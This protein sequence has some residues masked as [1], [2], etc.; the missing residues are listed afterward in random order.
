MN[1]NK[2]KGKRINENIFCEKA[3]YIMFEVGEE[4]ILPICV[5]GSAWAVSSSTSPIFCSYTTAAFFLLHTQPSP[6][7]HW[8]KRV[9]LYTCCTDILQLYS[10]VS[11]PYQLKVRFTVR[12]QD[13]LSWDWGSWI[14]KTKL[15]SHSSGFMSSALFCCT[16]DHPYLWY[17]GEAAV[18][19][20]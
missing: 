9:V 14:L 5:L 13:I 10:T 11:V 6:Q 8:P 20:Y 19:N 4:S 17:E 3:R 12:T 16:T 1:L 18:F 2:C 15:F 7:R